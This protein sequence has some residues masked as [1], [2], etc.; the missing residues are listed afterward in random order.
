MKS[1]ERPLR[2]KLRGPL[3]CLESPIVVLLLLVRYPQRIIE[4]PSLWIQGYGPGQ[5][6]DRFLI[7]PFVYCYS[8]F[9]KELLCFKLHVTRVQRSQ[10]SE[11]ICATPEIGGLQLQHR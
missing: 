1:R 8:R 2:R 5:C 6:D 9:T 7:L 4:M 3:E 10:T 11:S